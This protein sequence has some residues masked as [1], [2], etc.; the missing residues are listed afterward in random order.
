MENDN[1]IIKLRQFSII[2]FILS[3]IILISN[4]TVFIFNVEINS[5]ILLLTTL[6]GIIMLLNGVL[7][8]R[9]YLLNKW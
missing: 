6:S 3:A 8:R 4:L 9:K 2:S 7:Y 5:T 1:N